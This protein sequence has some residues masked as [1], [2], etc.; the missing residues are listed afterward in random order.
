MSPKKVKKPVIL[1]PVHDTPQPRRK[2]L[3]AVYQTEPKKLEIETKI[4]KQNIKVQPIRKSAAGRAGIK[5]E[6]STSSKSSR[7]RNASSRSENRN[8][9][10]VTKMTQ[11]ELSKKIE[12]VTKKEMVVVKRHLEIFENR[13]ALE[14]ESGIYERI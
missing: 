13:K 8:Y 11:L 12:S 6:R 7:T 14:Y 4:Q 2:N 3:F 5:K 10:L 9:Q 1:P